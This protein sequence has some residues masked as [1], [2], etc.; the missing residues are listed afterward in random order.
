M[1][2]L[3]ST[4]VIWRQLFITSEVAL[5]PQV[6]HAEAK[7]WQF[8]QAGANIFGKRQQVRQPVQLPIQPIPV[9]LWRIWFNNLIAARDLLSE[10]QKEEHRTV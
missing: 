9:S 3:S 1:S 10:K 4:T 6:S 8:V 7:D 2:H 5:Y